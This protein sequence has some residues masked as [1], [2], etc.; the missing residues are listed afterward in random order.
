MNPMSLYLI[1]TQSRTLSV[2]ISPGVVLNKPHVPAPGTSLMLNPNPPWLSILHIS[3]GHVSCILPP[4]APCPHL[5]SLLNTPG[6]GNL[7]AILR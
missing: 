3:P 5:Y 4:A 1:L 6:R 7:C 2:K